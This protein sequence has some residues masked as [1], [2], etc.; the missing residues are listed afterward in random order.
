MP[1][2]CMHHN[3]EGTCL[4]INLYHTLG[5]RNALPTELHNAL[6][7]VL[8]VLRRSLCAFSSWAAPILHALA[9]VYLQTKLVIALPL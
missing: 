8:G 4:K 6:A 3:S 9:A 1:D 5:L 2:Q 7:E